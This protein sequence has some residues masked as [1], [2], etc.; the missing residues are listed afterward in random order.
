MRLKFWKKIVKEEKPK[1]QIVYVP[2]KHIEEIIKLI[3]IFYQEWD[4]Y[5]L[6]LCNNNTNIDIIKSTNQAMEYKKHLLWNEVAELIPE[7][8]NKPYRFKFHVYKPYF[9]EIIDG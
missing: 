4:T 3:S 2:E 8:K 9:K 1:P 7:I 6:T 5:Y